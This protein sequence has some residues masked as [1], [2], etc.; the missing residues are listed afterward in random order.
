M[1]QGASAPPKAMVRVEGGSFSMGSQDFYA[2]ERPVHEVDVDGFW[3]DDHPVTVAEFRR[4]VKA[5]GWVTMAERPLDP[6]DYPDA[7]PDLLHPGSLVFRATSGPVDLSD[8]RNWWEYVPGASWRHP[9]GPGSTLDGRDRHPVVHVSYDDAEAYARWSGKELP[10]EAEWEFAA[11]GGLEGKTFAW[12]DEFAPRGKLMAN[13]WQGRF[14]WENLLEDG[15]MGTSPIRSFPPNGYGLWDMTGNVW[16]WTVD[17]YAPQHEATHACCGPA[18][19]PRVTSPD[20]SFNVGQPGGQFPRRVVK[21]GSHLCA[22]SYCLR[23]RPAARQPQT[24]ETSMAHLGFRC[25]I[26][27]TGDRGNGDDAQPM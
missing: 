8:Y 23:Y 4:F 10:T 12:G 25:V 2:E 18:S 19:N 5:T 20:A 26:R 9:E 22:P 6:A 7:D 13:T 15:H 17:Y 24:I 1:A 3:M 11:R 16:E 14:P 27:G 21:G